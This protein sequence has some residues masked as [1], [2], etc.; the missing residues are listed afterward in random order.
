MKEVTFIND[1]LVGITRWS[2]QSQVWLACRITTF[3]QCCEN[4][5]MAYC[6]QFLCDYTWTLEP[7]W[8]KLPESCCSWDMT[9]TRTGQMRGLS[10][11]DPHNAIIILEAK[12]T[13]VPPSKVFHRCCLHKKKVNMSFNLMFNL[14]K[15]IQW[16]FGSVLNKECSWDIAQFDILLPGNILLYSP[17][18]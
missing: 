5:N 17:F 18:V 8:K 1:K 13:S 3:T 11:S 10:D 15:S 16:M 9:F 14:P 6:D 2:P 12:G 7:I 4:E